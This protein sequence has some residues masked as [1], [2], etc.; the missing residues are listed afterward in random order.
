MNQTI[1]NIFYNNRCPNELIIYFYKFL[2]NYCNLCSVYHSSI[3]YNT[4]HYCQKNTPYCKLD[5]YK[6]NIICEICNTCS[7]YTSCKEK[8]DEDAIQC[9]AT[10]CNTLFCFKCS[11]NIFSEPF[12]CHICH[13][14]FICNSHSEMINNCKIC[15]NNRFCNSCVIQ[16]IH[17]LSYICLDCIDVNI[18]NTT[19]CYECIDIESNT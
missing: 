13:E 6:K 9:T 1:E 14:N 19:C 11:T 8:I 18:A 7:Y 15:F 16:C 4:C 3:D 12:R 10:G 2:P 5:Y 17:C